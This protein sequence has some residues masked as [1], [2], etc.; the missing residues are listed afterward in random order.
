MIFHEAGES[1]ECLKCKLVTR[2]YSP[3]SVINDQTYGGRCF[4]YECD[5]NASAEILKELN[6]KNYKVRITSHLDLGDMLKAYSLIVYFQSKKRLKFDLVNKTGSHKAQ[7]A[8]CKGFTYAE[9]KQPLAN[10]ISS[11]KSR[12]LIK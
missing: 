11:M 10:V 4:K 6:P 7:E 1:I 12:G 5:R 8:I 2:K 3:S 9:I